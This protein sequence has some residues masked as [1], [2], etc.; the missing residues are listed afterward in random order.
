VLA[1]HPIDAMAMP[2]ANRTILRHRY[3]RRST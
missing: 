2:V 1:L 3:I